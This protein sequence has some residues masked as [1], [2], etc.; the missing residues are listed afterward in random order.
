ME[1]D[2]YSEYK[3]HIHPS[4]QHYNN[5]S[6]T[7]HPYYAGNYGP[8]SMRYA[9][10][11]SPYGESGQQQNYFDGYSRYNQLH[12]HQHASYST[13]FNSHYGAMRENYHPNNE[14]SG[15]YFYQNAHQT[16]ASYYGNHSYDSF[17]N[18]STG[19]Q[20]N[21]YASGGGG[22]SNS[23]Y[24]QPSQYYSSYNPTEQ[25]NNRYYPTPP[26][27]APPTASQRDPYALLH[28]A[29]A[30]SIESEKLNERLSIEGDKRSLNKPIAS[31]PSS[32]AVKQSAESAEIEKKAEVQQTQLGKSSPRD[33]A[34]PNEGDKP[35]AS[36]G[37]KDD[38]NLDNEEKEAKT[39]K[40][41]N[42][43]QQSSSLFNEHGD[44]NPHHP[45]NESLTK[46]SAANSRDSAAGDVES[47]LATGKWKTKKKNNFH[48]LSI[49]TS[50]RRR[51]ER[52]RK[53]YLFLLFSVSLNCLLFPDSVTCN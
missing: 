1:M 9:H 33:S 21:H 26:P 48:E 39:T 46:A 51:R 25:F 18:A 7:N 2:C 49:F 12:H 10:A 45:Y 28:E 42:Q 16:S 24:N 44:H 3:H 53:I 43:H 34:T 29:Y 41:E 27:S 11:H 36:E 8:T 14:G 38:Q 4:H 35:N 5:S 20:Y 15:Q 50:V 32:P 40:H 19:Y 6:A 30:P 52:K 37:V 47:S 13:S 22:S 17:H 23:G 31:S